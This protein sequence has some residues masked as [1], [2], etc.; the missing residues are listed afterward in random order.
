MSA[1]DVVYTGGR[2]EIVEK[3]SRFI[4]Q[5]FPVHS[6]EEAAGL[7]E[8]IRKEYWDARHHCYAFVIGSGNEISRS[9]D[10]GEPSG[11]AGRPI[12]EVLTG[13][14]IHDALIIVTRYFGGTLLGTGG[15]VR[16]YSR[17]AQAGLA[18]SR[19]VTK[20]PGRKVMIRM[21]Y[22]GIGKLQH[23]LA[24]MDVP[25]LDTQYTEAV[26]MAVLI[27]EE[28]KDRLIREVTEAT[29]GQ[30]EIRLSEGLLFGVLEGKPVFMDQE[31]DGF[32]GGNR[33]AAFNG[34]RSAREDRES[35][36]REGDHGS[37]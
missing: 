9:S 10:D 2:D 16:A 19:I 15:L 21:D 5:V 32:V 25:V 27:P 13:R 30:A 11:T 23:V 8:G 29:A 37:V 6:Q 3:K 36:L 24:G 7:I 18:A 35:C 1:Y 28:Q 20:Q 12:L 26:E 14:G 17:A 34:S 31:R 33:N 22:S 4:A